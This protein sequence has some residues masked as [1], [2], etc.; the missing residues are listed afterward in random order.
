M[1]QSTGLTYSRVIADAYRQQGMYGVLFRGYFPW[2]AAQAM[3]KGLP[4]LFV[5]GEAKDLALRMGA[6]ANE[7]TII[8]GIAGGVS[9]GV[10]VTPTQ[11]LKTL[12]MTKPDSMVHVRGVPPCL[13]ALWHELSANC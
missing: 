11:R 12:I 1:R 13:R 5:T 4:I 3:T 10:V 6:S 9:Q 2:G 7:A 8:G